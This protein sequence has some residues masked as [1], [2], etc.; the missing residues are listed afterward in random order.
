MATYSNEL[1]MVIVC[2]SGRQEM[3]GQLMD[4]RDKTADRIEVLVQMERRMFTLN[5][6]DYQMAKISIREMCVLRRLHCVAD[7]ACR[8]LL[9]LHASISRAVLRELCPSAHF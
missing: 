4:L 9:V 3:L 8:M 2:V 7:D 6:V 1:L 5:T